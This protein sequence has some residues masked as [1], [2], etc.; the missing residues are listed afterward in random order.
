MTNQ[1]CLKQACL[2]HRTSSPEKPAVGSV[3][4]L[5][6]VLRNWPL[7][8]AL[9]FILTEL[10][11]L[12]LK[13]QPLSPQKTHPKVRRKGKTINPF[14]SHLWQ[15]RG[16]LATHPSPLTW[17]T[18][19]TEEPARLQPTGSLRVGRDWWDSATA[20]ACR[21]RKPGPEQPFPHRP[22]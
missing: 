8:H 18:P 16:A 13:L 11:I 10:E 5:Q 3:L 17:K 22:E 6:G 19:W 2:P 9:H 21:E 1:R 4:L 15:K 12:S 14:S 20:A 7:F